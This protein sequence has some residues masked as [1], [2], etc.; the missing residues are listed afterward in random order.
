MNRRTKSKTF[1]KIKGKQI[2]ILLEEV[3]KNLD[4]Y[5]KVLELRDKQLSDAKKV[6]L[7]AK[8]SYDKTVAENKELRAYI[9]TIKNKFT[10]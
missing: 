2:N 1:Q 3:E 4:E 10:K 7:S 6:L 9:D 8:K 5:K